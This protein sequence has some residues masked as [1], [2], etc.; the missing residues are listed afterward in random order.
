M[1]RVSSS[2]SSFS[3]RSK[4]PRRGKEMRK[5]SKISQSRDQRVSRIFLRGRVHIKWCI[6]KEK[7]WKVS[8]CY[9]SMNRELR[10]TIIELSWDLKLRNNQKLTKKWSFQKGWGHLGWDPIHKFS[11]NLLNLPKQIWESES[12]SYKRGYSWCAYQFPSKSMQVFN[13]W[14]TAHHYSF[15]PKA[16]LMIITFR[17]HPFE[18]SC[19]TMP[20]LKMRCSLPLRLGH[21]NWI[22]ELKEVLEECFLTQ[23]ILQNRKVTL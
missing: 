5:A 22:W 21:S 11:I 3:T 1:S 10:L 18:S 6:F 2:Q 19:S 13:T 8:L 9:L 17:A 4:D 14:R 16:C 15:S 23:P 20:H 7:R 12:N